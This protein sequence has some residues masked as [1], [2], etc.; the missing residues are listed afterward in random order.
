[1]IAYLLD[2]L[3]LRTSFS[4]FK[5]LKLSKVDRYINN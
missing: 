2:V 5:D 3:I 4:G 1:M